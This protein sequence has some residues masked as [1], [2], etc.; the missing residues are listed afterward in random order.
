MDW[1]ENLDG[2][3]VGT[4][5]HIALWDA[6]NALVTASGGTN[7]VSVSRMNCVAGVEAALRQLLGTNEAAPDAQRPPL[8]AVL[9]AVAAERARQDHKWGGPEADDARKTEIDWVADIQAY[10]AW[11][12]QMH[13]SGSPEKYRRR[14]MQVAALAVAA[15]ES[16]DRKA[17]NAAFVQPGM[18]PAVTAWRLEW[19]EHK[20]NG[21]D[22][23]WDDGRY[24]FSIVFDPDDDEDVRYLATWGEGPEDCFSTLEDAQRW[25]QNIIDAWIRENVVLARREGWPSDPLS[26]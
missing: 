18:A 4:P 24:G 17:A 26:P 9:E 14:M 20:H 19:T 7:T 2:R 6:I 3:L 8:S 15:C 23:Q 12:C 25:C 13:R 21:R 1:I 11:A 22:R 10:V 16:Y 5:A